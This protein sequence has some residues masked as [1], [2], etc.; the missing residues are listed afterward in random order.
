[1]KKC[2]AILAALP[3]EVAPLVRNWPSSTHFDR[4]GASLWECDGAIVVC[5]G[6][7]RKRVAR[8]LELA[9]ARSSVE[10]KNSIESKGSIGSIF[11]VGYAGALRSGMATNTV[12]WPATVI[13]AQ[14]GESFECEGG[15]GTLV[16]SDHVVHAAEKQELAA[17]WNAD[18]V[19]MEAAAVAR[20]AQ[21]RNLPFR[22]LRVISDE[23]ADTLPDL[24]R[25]TD[26]AG[27]FRETAFAV[28]LGLH[29]WLIPAAVRMGKRAAQGSR[30]IAETLRPICE[31][32]E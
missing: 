3:R 26:D 8:A 32:S 22:T 30:L 9:E 29:P 28:Y 17:R 25:F 12:Y 19:D 5:A 14:T 10:S 31:Q 15:D 23:V 2:I 16:T 7:G 20:L 18:L 1:M 4:E 11:S 6:M 27:G 13:D 21:T 24:G